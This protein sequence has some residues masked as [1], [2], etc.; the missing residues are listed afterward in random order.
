MSRKDLRL[1]IQRQMIGIACH[2]HMGDHCL[3]RD[4]ALDQPRRRRCLHDGAGA[5]PAGELRT[6]G[7]DHPKLRRDHV[8][9]LRGV[10]ADYRHARPAARARR[11]N[12]CQRY[13]DPRQVG[14]QCTTA[15]AARGGIVQAPLGIPLLRLGICFGDCL[16]DRFEAQLQLFLRQTLR[17]GAEMHPS[18]LQQQ[19]TQPVI[20]C[21][22]DVPLR[23][24]RITFRH[25]CQHQR[26]QCFNAFGQALQVGAW[27][28]HHATNPT[29]R[30]TV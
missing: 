1:A 6:L 20:L 22:Q 11:V 16:L 13:L 7:Y 12:G 9:P 27:G 29:R 18:Q 23:D 8:Q 5:G 30:P 15:R 10:L 2:Q 4:A 3:G 25:H 24:R 17:P 28:I 14:G 21:Q 26:A 19:M